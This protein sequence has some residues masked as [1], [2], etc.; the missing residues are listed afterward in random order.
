MSLIKHSPRSMTPWFGFDRFFEDFDRSFG[1]KGAWAP[2]VD[3]YEDEKA[4]TLKAELPDMDEKNLDVLHR[5]KKALKPSGRFLLDVL[6]RDFAAREAPH[7]HWFEG[8]G[9]VC[10]DDMSL[11]WITNR[12]RLKRSIILDDGRSKELHSSTRLYTLSEVGRM[13]HDV[14][15]RV[16]AVSGDIATKGAFFGP[17][18]RRIIILSGKP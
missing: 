1:E 11:D 4:I 16:S 2:A 3:I 17:H 7:N 9:C 8:D 5:V 6:N 13:L 14:G 18:S 12:L 10:M 15:F